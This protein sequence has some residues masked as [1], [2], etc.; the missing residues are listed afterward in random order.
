MS[1][2]NPQPNSFTDKKNVMWVLLSGAMAAMFIFLLFVPGGSDANS[3]LS[4]YAAMLWCGIFLATVF[5]YF[6]KNGWIG[7]I[8]GSVVGMLI[9]MLS[10][11]FVI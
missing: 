11:M 5:R 8:V 10:V 2:T 6:G 1:E 3:T 9:Q 4:V 7:F